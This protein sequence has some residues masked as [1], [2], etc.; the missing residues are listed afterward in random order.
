VRARLGVV[1]AAGA[2]EVVPIPA[3]VVERWYSSHIYSWWQP[4][5]TTVSNATRWALLDAALI[6]LATLWLLLAVRDARRAGWRALVR[7]AWR[8]VVW[9]AAAYLI[10]LGSWGLNY[11]R[12]PLARKLALDNERVTAEAARA[13]AA[14]AVVRTNSLYEPA[15]RDGFPAGGVVDSRLAAAFAEAQRDL[16]ATWRAVAARP[17]TTILDGYF[18]RAVVDGM[19]DPFFLETL[20]ASDLLPYERTF[21]IAHEWGHLAGYADEGEANFVGWLTCVRGDEAAQYSGWL[22]LTNEAAAALPRRQRD[23]VFARLDAGPR[24]DLRD[25]SSRIARNERP[26]VAAAGWR[27]YDRYLKA[28]RVEAGTRSYSEVVRLILGSRFAPASLRA[29][30]D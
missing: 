30:Q 9:C 8:T 24:A 10:F 27:V 5:V 6:V 29:F 15:R 11:R 18:R 21:V 4:L 28:N 16:G 12:V 2:A 26:A 17:K 14:T 13:L 25:I 19:T 20:T 1:I 23:D 22:F 3:S 7:V